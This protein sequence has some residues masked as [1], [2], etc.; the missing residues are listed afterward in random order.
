MATERPI[1]FET[2]ETI[3]LLDRAKLTYA[4][5]THLWW[6]IPLA[7][8]VVPFLIWFSFEWSTGASLV[9][10]ILLPMFPV[11]SFAGT[12]FILRH[13]AYRD[14]RHNLEEVSDDVRLAGPLAE[15]LRV[16]HRALHAKVEE[17]L[18]RIL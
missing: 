17:T 12:F 16:K 4:G 5:Q 13:E 2:E 8:M 14:V 18:I 9:S 6:A 10:G 11:M 7:T 1:R 15:S 3:R